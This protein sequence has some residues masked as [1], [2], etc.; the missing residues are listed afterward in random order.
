M[1]FFYQIFVVFLE[2]LNFKSML[3]QKGY[4]PIEDTTG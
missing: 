4:Y 2:N 3:L 1:G